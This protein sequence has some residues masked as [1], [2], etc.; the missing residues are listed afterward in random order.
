MFDSLRFLRL[1]EFLIIFEGFFYL[2]AWVFC[3]SSEV[4]VCSS[5]N[6]HWRIQLEE[7]KN[8]SVSFQTLK[9]WPTMNFCGAGIAGI[10]DHEFAFRFP[11]DE[12]SSTSSRQKR[13]SGKPSLRRQ[14]SFGSR[15]STKTARGRSK[16][17]SLNSP[18]SLQHNPGS[19]QEYERRNQS[20]PLS[21]MKASSA[22]MR[23]LDSGFNLVSKRNKV[24]H[25]Y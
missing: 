21:A 15:H 4:L 7:S 20:H 6:L 11:D 2:V 19:R 23:K 16:M 3:D 22:L 1:S 12:S 24:I 5:F 9:S 10:T 17:A 25:L 14:G 13:S 8:R 18:S